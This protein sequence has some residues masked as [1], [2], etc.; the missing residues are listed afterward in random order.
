MNKGLSSIQSNSG[1]STIVS[2][3]GGQIQLSGFNRET[4]LDGAFS[5]SISDRENDALKIQMS[6][7]ICTQMGTQKQM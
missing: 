3:N 4:D 7:F 6:T 2:G 5:S 1:A